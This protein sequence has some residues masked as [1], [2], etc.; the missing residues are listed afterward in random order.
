MRG[1]DSRLAGFLT[2]HTHVIRSHAETHGHIMR[3]RTSA[4][5]TNITKCIPLRWIMIAFI[6]EDKWSHNRSL[7]CSGR[8]WGELMMYCS[9]VVMQ[10]CLIISSTGN[11]M[12][13]IYRFLIPYKRIFSITWINFRLVYFKREIVFSFFC[14]A[15][16]E[17]ADCLDWW[18]RN[19]T[20]FNKSM[21]S[22]DYD[23]FE[24]ITER[25]LYH[26]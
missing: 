16:N 18:Y 9:L 10:N 2:F 5:F 26:A 11:W 15:A 20:K 25:F 19:G 7:P 8:E 3:Q 14:H 23:Y 24:V 6:T 1:S 17:A 21:Q 13:I 22:M 12:W 4:Q